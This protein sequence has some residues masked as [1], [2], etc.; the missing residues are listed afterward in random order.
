MDR[1]A[2]MPD[3]DQVTATSFSPDSIVLARN[4]IGL[5]YGFS[6]ERAACHFPAAESGREV[7]ALIES[8][9]L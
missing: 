7:R 9:L 2:E 3:P 6:A 5:D 8:F 1:H 4:S